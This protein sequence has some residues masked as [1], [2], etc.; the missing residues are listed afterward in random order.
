VV[1]SLVFVGWLY[2]L[3]LVLGLAATPVLLGP[4]RWLMGIVHLWVRLVLWGL[5]AFVGQRVEVRGLEH[6]PT[7][8]A[9]VAAKHLS[10]L[11]T[12]APFQVLPDPCFVLKKELM[13]LP[14]YGWFARKTD[15]IP[16]NRGGGSQAV[17]E[18]S[19][20][21]QDRLRHARQILIFPEGTRK[22]LGAEPHYKGGVAALYRDLA[23]P[24]TPMA[25]NSGLFWPAH[26]FVRRPGVVVFEF[27]EP[28]P[29][30]LARAAFMRELE[31]RV[32]TATNRLL[33]EGGFEAPER[34]RRPVAESEAAA[35]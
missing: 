21:A 20:A 12:I 11:D 19:A 17:R 26:G 29:P 35:R 4:R 13:R 3:M 7:G 1:R 5:R 18:L 14:I 33:A 10:M 2:G 31:E 30:G 34:P 25:T 6:R 23:L 8:A 27:L 9:I 16:V 24:C 28:I 22:E 15:M 32:E